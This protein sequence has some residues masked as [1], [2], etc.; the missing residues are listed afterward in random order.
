M[1][2][3]TCLI[4]V[5]RILVD[6]SP[7]VGLE[8]E[9]VHRSNQ[10]FVRPTSHFAPMPRIPVACPLRAVVKAR[11]WAAVSAFNL[12]WKVRSARDRTKRTIP[13][14]VRSE[15]F[16]NPGIFERKFKNFG[17]FQRSLNYRR[18]SDK[19]SSKSEQKSMK[20]TNFCKVYQKM[21]KKLTKIFWNIE[22]W[23]VQKH[24]IL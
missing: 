2:V 3:N 12:S 16:Q 23:A 4:R 15:L 11:A 6:R 7:T 13:I 19:I 9:I 24:W 10:N 20:K 8:S 21:R 22:V 14:R 18:N 5:E 17:K 1:A